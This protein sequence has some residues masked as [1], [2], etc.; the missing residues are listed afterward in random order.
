[1]VM[2]ETP[3]TGVCARRLCT[4]LA[5]ATPALAMSVAIGLEPLSLT[6]SPELDIRYVPCR[7]R[8]QSSRWR[9]PS[10]R[11]LGRGGQS[12]AH[13]GIRKPP[14]HTGP[15][16]TCRGASAGRRAGAVYSHSG[17]L[18]LVWWSVPGEGSA[19][20]CHPLRAREGNP[21]PASL[22]CSPLYPNPAPAG[23]PRAG[24]PLPHR[25]MPKPGSQITIC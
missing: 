11:D 8:A 21:Q 12:A 24:P 15:S 4:G 3:E 16:A 7:R 20:Y 17:V 22:R 2:E 9:V 10:A 14:G 23:F 1:M 25:S 6:L 13:R 19:V 5:V 18:G